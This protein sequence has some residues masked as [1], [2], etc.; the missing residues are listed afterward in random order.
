MDLLPFKQMTFGGLKPASLSQLNAISLR[1]G[2]NIGS[3]FEMRQALCY[4]ASS[5]I[6][7][8]KLHLRYSG[9]M[10]PVIRGGLFCYLYA[11]HQKLYDS[12]YWVSL[13]LT[14]T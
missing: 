9:S 12:Q 6:I 11:S 13:R 8:T 3:T 4:V 5:G 2:K 7:R 10:L 1:Y 14:C